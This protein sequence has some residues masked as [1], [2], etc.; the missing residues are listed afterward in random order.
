MW[1]IIKI[2]VI[3]L[4]ELN[5]YFIL[6]TAMSKI[7]CF[8]SASTDGWKFVYGFLS[9]HV[10]FWCIAFPCTMGNASVTAL[11]ILWG[12]I[13]LALLVI[14]IWLCGIRTLAESYKGLF[15]M[16][17]RYK[18]YIL[19]LMVL[20]GFLI[21]YVC[22]NGQSDI[23]ARFYIGEVT[24]RL[25]TNRLAGVE[26]YAGYEINDIGW[27]H[28]FSMIGANS[29][30]LCKIFHIRPL[31]F[32]RTVRAAINI[33]L[34]MAVSFELFWWAYREKKHR[35]EH[36]VMAVML[37]GAFLFLFA[38][39]IYTPSAFILH[40]TYEGKAYCGGVLVLL[41]IN[42]IIK[43]CETN[44]RRHFYLIFMCMLTS[45]SLC[46]SSVFL[47][48]ILAGSMILA[49]VL[50]SHRWKYLLAYLAAVLPNIVYLAIYILKI[51]S[52][53]LC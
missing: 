41:L 20:M 51:P 37:S 36:T 5:I 2:V 15:S 10:L 45:M 18:L 33:L 13:L 8:P 34:L 29:A 17:L 28:A 46:P 7:K 39:T 23:D 38:N 49:Y 32:C 40:R 22:V 48:P 30:V 4:I 26:V 14:L 9:Y 53:Q 27:K 21:Y 24:T 3:L 16:L 52:F 35:F 50:Y 11:A 31:V 6:G 47:L 44:D 19:P 1:Y 25:D 43:L 42:L 12:I